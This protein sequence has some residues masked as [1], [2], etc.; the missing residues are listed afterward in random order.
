MQ[1][2]VFNPLSR[3]IVK[4]S[5]G[6]FDSWIV[7]HYL[8]GRV[9]VGAEVPHPYGTAEA[10]KQIDPRDLARWQ[11][12]YADCEVVVR[13][14]SEAQIELAYRFAQQYARE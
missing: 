14:A 12:K 9:V 6:T 5:D 1:A 10:T 13:P 11:R 8:D 2:L 3:V 4:R 7:L